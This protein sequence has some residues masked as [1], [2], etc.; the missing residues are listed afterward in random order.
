M[1]QDLGVVGEKMAHQT[2]CRL[3]RWQS[4]PSGHKC[5]D[6]PDDLG[7]LSTHYRPL[8]RQFQAF[9]DTSAAASLGARLSAQILADRPEARMETVRSLVVHS[10]E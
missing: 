7:L 8:L 10:A 1:Q 6:T 9:G 4:C 5:V 2:G 3:G